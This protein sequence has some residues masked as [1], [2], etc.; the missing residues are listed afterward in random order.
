MFDVSEREIY[1]A[2]SNAAL[3]HDVLMP[4]TE[5][6][7]FQLQAGPEDEDSVRGN[8]S[9]NSGKPRSNSA[10]ES[11]AAPKHRKSGS[12]SVLLKASQESVT[13]HSLHP[14]HMDSVFSVTAAKVE[15]AKF[16]QECVHKHLAAV[17]EMAQ[18]HE[19]ARLAQ[20]AAEQAELAL[21]QSDANAGSCDAPEE[22]KC[23]AEAE[24]PA[25]SALSS[26][27]LDGEAV[28]GEGS[29]RSRRAVS[30]TSETG[31]NPSPSKL[32]AATGVATLSSSTSLKQLNSGKSINVQAKSLRWSEIGGILIGDGAG[33]SAG[34][35]YWVTSQL[36]SDR[37]WNQNSQ[38]PSPVRPQPNKDEVAALANSCS[39]DNDD[40]ADTETNEELD[41]DSGDDNRGPKG[42]SPRDGDSEDSDDDSSVE[43]DVE[44]IGDLVHHTLSL[45]VTV[46]TK[47]ARRS[48]D[49]SCGPSAELHAENDAR[50]HVSSSAELL[51]H[52]ESTAGQYS[53]AE[54]KSALTVPSCQDSQRSGT[55]IPDDIFAALSSAAQDSFHIVGLSLENLDSDVRAFIQRFAET[56]VC[57]FSILYTTYFLL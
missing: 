39:F 8:Q 56:Q 16:V 6:L 49:D 7:L 37:Q 4:G 48:S 15:H 34:S 29:F 18:A 22:E 43:E 2:G 28:A 35:T 54:G 47:D 20:Q 32:A 21:A 9:R 13:G 11:T 36:K 12:A 26:S 30:A 52:S 45:D 40:E 41:A 24:T 19:K 33:S 44:I 38:P 27:S 31:S 50:D 25:D 10:A 53:P 1:V 17:I 5:G 51:L 3:V 14:Q 23:A 55:H 57:M 42:D 46:R